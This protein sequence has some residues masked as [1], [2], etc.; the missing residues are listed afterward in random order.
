LIIFELAAPPP[1]AHGTS[2]CTQSNRGK[3]T[4]GRAHDERMTMSRQNGELWLSRA[5][6]LC[7]K[8]ASA[9]ESCEGRSRLVPP[10]EMVA[11][12][13]CRFQTGACRG[14][15]A[16]L[17]LDHAKVV[18]HDARLRCAPR[19]ILQGGQ[20]S[21]NITQF[22]PHPSRGIQQ[23]RVGGAHEA[24]GQVPGALQA[25]V[26]PAVSHQ[27]HR[28]IIRRENAAGEL[29]TKSV[30]QRYGRLRL[31]LPF[32]E[33]C[34]IPYEGCL[35][36]RRIDPTLVG[37]DGT[38]QIAGGH[39]H[40]SQVVIGHPPAGLQ[41]NSMMQFADRRGSIRAQQQLS[42]N[43][44]QGGV[45][46]PARKNRAQPADGPIGL[47]TGI[48]E[49]RDFL[50]GREGIRLQRQRTLERRGGLLWPVLRLGD[51]RLDVGTAPVSW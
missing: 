18:P 8:D 33:R 46:G 27:Q 36:L 42:K 13:H 30:V 25:R 2:E 37:P 5:A 7:S 16:H 51:Q 3:S 1:E 14:P 50:Q 22:E 15:L 12:S 35:Q 17:Q 38:R 28:K 9:A 29:P 41:L 10:I 34:Q 26:V 47:A 43:I 11:P 4:V 40:G 19:R 44:M 39:L 31:A 21:C 49:P 45:I 23:I 20:C 24:G 6:G 48:F 32:V